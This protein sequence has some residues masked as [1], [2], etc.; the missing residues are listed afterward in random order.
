MNANKLKAKDLI[1]IAIFSLIFYAV[2]I[3]VGT[4]LW[5]SIVL[6]PFCVAASILPCGIVWTYMRVKVPKRFSILI[7]AA[8]L[9][10]IC[11]LVGSG[12]FVSVG[13]IV[14]GLLAEFLSGLGKH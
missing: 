14:G 10:I 9:A 2:Y 13:L 7:Q 1:T 6:N 5:M 3:I 4:L 11:F 8:L 12:W